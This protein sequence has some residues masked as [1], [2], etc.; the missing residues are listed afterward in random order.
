MQL[1]SLC[2]TRY[3]SAT[4]E[5]TPVSSWQQQSQSTSALAYM[6]SP[7]HTTAHASNS[8]HYVLDLIQL[9]HHAA[10]FS[11]D[12]LAETAPTECLLLSTADDSLHSSTET[13]KMR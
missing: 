7:K 6:T 13:L 8:V 1:V 9:R 2:G 12:L 10:G 11:E 5:C 4:G 3:I